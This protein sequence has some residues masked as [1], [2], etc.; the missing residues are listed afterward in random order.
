MD[1][2]I[3]RPGA[4]SIPTAEASDDVVSSPRDDD[5][6]ASGASQDVV[7]GGPKIVPGL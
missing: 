6:G 4:N 3:A 7:P 2:S 5:V 1:H